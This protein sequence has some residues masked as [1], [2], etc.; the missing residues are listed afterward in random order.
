MLQWC[1]WT[2][3]SLFA[4]LVIPLFLSYCTGF[5]TCSFVKD[6]WSLCWT[7]SVVFPLFPLT[8]LLNVTFLELSSTDFLRIWIRDMTKAAQGI[9]NAQSKQLQLSPFR[10]LNKMAFH[11][12]CFNFSDF[13]VTVPSLSSVNVSSLT[14]DRLKRI[15]CNC[16]GWHFA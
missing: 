12:R 5:S 8:A 1:L 15:D 13:A 9:K 4:Q 6:E 14:A 3:C 11:L 10:F 16:F 7:L 2:I